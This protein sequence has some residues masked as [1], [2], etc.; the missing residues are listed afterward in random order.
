MIIKP[1]LEAEDYKTR[2][3]FIR[4]FIQR[5]HGQSSPLP[6]SNNENYQVYRVI[7]QTSWSTLEL[8]ICFLIIARG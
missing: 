5:S 7:F 3:Y 8:I 6:L 2:S 1:S 4:A